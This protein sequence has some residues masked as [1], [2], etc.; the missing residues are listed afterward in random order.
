MSFFCC[1]LYSDV[2]NDLTLDSSI[3]GLLLASI[4]SEYDLYLS[5]L[6]QSMNSSNHNEIIQT[7][8]LVKSL[9]P[10]KDNQSDDS[11][12]EEVEQLMK[13]SR[14]ALLRYLPNVAILR[15]L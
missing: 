13:Q 12:R 9:S 3:F 14:D 2:W 4:K 7:L 5:H 1:Q 10:S 8:G 11:L 6:L 15:S